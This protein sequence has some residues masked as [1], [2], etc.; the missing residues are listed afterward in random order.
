MS[1]LT[2]SFASELASLRRLVQLSSGTPAFAFALC[3]QPALRREIISQVT[4]PD[5]ALAE[6]PEDTEDPV[7]TARAQ[8]PVEHRGAVFIKGLEKL[9]SEAHAD[10]A[11]N[12][13][14]LN[15]S[16]ER[17]RSRFPAQLLVFWVTEQAL[18]RILRE[19]PDFRAWVSHEFDFV[20]PLSLP[21][22]IKRQAGS[23]S[24]ESAARAASILERLRHPEELP[25]MQR[26]SLIRELLRLAPA[27]Q[28]VTT[29]VES[30]IHESLLSLRQRAAAA[31]SRAQ[32]DLE[33]AL[34]DV[35]ASYRE[36]GH[37]H[38]ARRHYEE[39]HAIAERLAAS[40]PANAAW[41]RDLSISLEKLGDLAVA[42]GDLAG[43]LRY[44]TEAKAIAERLAAS[45]PANA[46]W[47]RDLSVSLGK[48]GDLAVAQ[49]DLTGALRYFT[50][51]KAISERLAASDLANAAWQRDLSVSLNRL[52]DLAVAQGDL[53]G[54]LRSFTESKAI[55]E[56]LAASDPAN[57]AW[58]RDLSV[59]LEKRGN[60]AVAQGDLTGALRSFT[61]SKAIRERLAA[62]D[63]AN[64]EWQR[65]L[66]V[67][68]VKL[69][70]HCEKSGQTAAA[71]A[72]WQKAHDTLAGMKARSLHLTPQDEAFL[73][74]LKMKVTG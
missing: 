54:A 33:L 49:G 15:R 68:F 14:R 61:E 11:G 47:Q 8:I 21:S 34:D 55:S 48:L 24:T 67:S 51:A 18:L 40:D 50:E 3:N 37:S 73:D 74:R 4:G 63:P 23:V 52:G 44:F 28:E 69:A 31:D 32:R 41:Q 42:Q 66:C 35:A 26:L 70:G 53:A 19:A 29:L 1:D 36:L 10:S 2:S 57:A 17:W 43:S 38:A 6:L 30:G 58:Q 16:R 64:A 9:L 65:D 46:E 56:R 13:A 7:A 71:K 72:W 45:D 39:S 62:S 5:V 12:I 22:T 25:P 59:S 27:S 60:L 20:E